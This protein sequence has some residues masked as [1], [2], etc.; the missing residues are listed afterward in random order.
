MANTQK[1]KTQRM[2]GIAI[3]TALVLVL[4][5]LATTIPMKPFSITLTLVPIVIGS[6]LYG[7]K[8]GAYLGGVF[9][10]VVLWG[11][12]SGL[13]VGGQ[14]MLNASPVLCVILVLLKGTAA[15]FCS[16]IVYKAVSKKNEIVASILAGIVSPVVNTGIFIAGA[17]LFFRETLAIWAGG[18]DLM[19][20]II[21]GLAGVNFLIELGINLVLNPVIIRVI[22]VIKKDKVTA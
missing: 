18:T 2:V 8:V 22:H 9:S 16:G 15:G 11:C 10:L 1:Q 5:V 13:D 20:Y 6:A 12:L 21:T 7:P 14:M 19:L 17:L 3:L 4:Q